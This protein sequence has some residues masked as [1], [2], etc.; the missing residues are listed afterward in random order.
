MSDTGL[1]KET[2]LPEEEMTEKELD[3]LARRLT[4]ITEENFDYFWKQYQYWKEKRQEKK[5]EELKEDM[6]FVK[7]GDGSN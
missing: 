4:F 1:E 6:M 2:R 3:E 5:E 7:E